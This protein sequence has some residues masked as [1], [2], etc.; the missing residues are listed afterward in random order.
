MFSGHRFKLRIE[1]ENVVIAFGLQGVR[2][3]QPDKNSKEVS[4]ISDQAKTYAKTTLH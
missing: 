3:P 2:S 1:S 4:E